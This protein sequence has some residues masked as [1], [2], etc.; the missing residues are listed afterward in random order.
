MGLYKVFDP[1]FPC[2]LGNQLIFLAYQNLRQMYEWIAIESDIRS[3]SNQLLSGASSA[4]T[5]FSK[6][7]RRG[8]VFDAYQKD[9]TQRRQ[10]L[11]GKIFPS[12]RPCF[13]EYC[14]S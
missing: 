8:L 10:S 9:S 4:H 14:P 6:E 5:S 1:A 3:D 13:P 12:G 2:L 11:Y 7:S